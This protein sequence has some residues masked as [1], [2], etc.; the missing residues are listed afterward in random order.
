MSLDTILRINLLLGFITVGFAFL[1][2]LVWAPK[3]IRWYDR[4]K[5][6]PHEW[7]LIGIS[8]GFLSTIGDNIF[9][10]ITWYSK[11]KAWPTSEWWFDHGPAANLLF[12]H[13]GKIAAAGCHLEAA[14]QANVLSSC[15]LS[16]RSAAIIMLSAVLTF[17]LL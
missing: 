16:S 13:V 11:M 6:G 10:G 12:R 2:L 9:W 5:L 17:L 1:V 4:S 3:F 7:L 15:E 8:L 14:R